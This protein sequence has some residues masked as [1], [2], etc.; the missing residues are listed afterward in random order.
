MP[1]FVPARVVNC[2]P[3]PSEECVV[4]ACFLHREGERMAIGQ[5]V[6]RDVPRPRRDYIGYRPRPP[7]VR[8]PHNATLGPNIIVNYEGGSE[9]SKP[10]GDRRTETVAEVRLH[11][12]GSL[13][14][15]GCGVDVR[16]LQPGGDL[17]GCCDCSMSTKST[18][19]SLPPLRRWA[20]H[21]CRGAAGNLKM[22][23]KPCSWDLAK[24]SPAGRHRARR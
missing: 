5:Q 8:W 11:A 21:W 1:A 4:E 17:G 6:D 10:L 2:A 23:G 22:K 3:N 19:R 20:S 15:P 7:R 12:S 18:S 9:D 24:G 16:V 14:R 13:P